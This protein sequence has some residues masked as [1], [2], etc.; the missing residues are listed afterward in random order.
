MT[1]ELED[2]LAALEK[3]LSIAKVEKYPPQKSDSSHRL[4]PVRRRRIAVI[5]AGILI[6]IGIIAAG[7]GYMLLTKPRDVIPSRI[8]NQVLFPLYYP[9]D[10][11]N[12]YVVN[13]RSFEVTEQVV[14]YRL[15]SPSSPQILISQQPRVA[16]FNYDEFNT[17][18][19]GNPSAVLTQYGKAVIGVGEAGKIA[20]LVTDKTWI[21]MTSDG[22]TSDATI[23]RLMESIRISE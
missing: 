6:L 9:T 21:F 19:V 22:E 14:S 23:R 15:E 10:L 18:K 13:E 3:E 12:G 16:S 20:S 4:K 5:T 11:P 7:G 17:Q 2:R 1:K 8:S